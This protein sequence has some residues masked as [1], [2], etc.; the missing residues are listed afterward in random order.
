MFIYFC[1][2]V[3]TGNVMQ[4]YSGNQI[5]NRLVTASPRVWY[6]IYA[7]ETTINKR[8]LLA[9]LYITQT[10][11]WASERARAAAP[12]RA[13]WMLADRQ[14]MSRTLLGVRPSLQPGLFA[15]ENWSYRTIVVDRH[16]IYLVTEPS[17]A[18]NVKVFTC[19]GRN[20]DFENGV[21]GW[22]NGLSG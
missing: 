2:V 7:T 12:A 4:A 19:H 6:V 14:V 15:C 10:S 8:H 20:H 13:L 18:A 11:L 22:K 5:I 16:R 17:I 9:K 1:P 21:P 3:H